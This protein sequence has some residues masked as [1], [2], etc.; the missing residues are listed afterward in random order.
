MKLAV[1]LRESGLWWTWHFGRG[2]VINEM[3]LERTAD[4]L[5]SSS[6]TQGLLTSRREWRGDP[7][8]D[9]EAI[10]LYTAISHTSLYTRRIAM[11]EREYALRS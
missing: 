4:N 7:V 1:R 6:G 11:W 5:D 9:K 2:L 10:S 8:V 3:Q